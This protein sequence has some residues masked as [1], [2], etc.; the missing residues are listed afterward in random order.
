MEN[1]KRLE[2]YL[3]RFEEERRIKLKLFMESEKK[4]EENQKG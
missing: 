3:N 1:E 4:L 2:E